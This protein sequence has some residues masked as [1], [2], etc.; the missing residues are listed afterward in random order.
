VCEA[1]HV[2]MSILK[3]LNISLSSISHLV[4]K[5]M[6]RVSVMLETNLSILSYQL[7][8]SKASHKHFE[9]QQEYKVSGLDEF[10]L[11]LR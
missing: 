9:T 7:Y 11:F 4:V 6:Q 2:W 1:A 3:G 10:I 5:E 8:V